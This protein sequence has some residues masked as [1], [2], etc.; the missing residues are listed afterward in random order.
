[1]FGVFNVPGTST[2]N[3]INNNDYNN[4]YFNVKHVFIIFIIG[5]TFGILLTILYYKICIEK[6]CNGYN[7]IRA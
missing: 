1:M 5:I 6:T 4:T 2:L 7:K 3:D